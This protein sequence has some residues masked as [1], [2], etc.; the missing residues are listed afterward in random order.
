MIA[1]STDKFPPGACIVVFCLRGVMVYTAV[2]GIQFSP[3]WVDGSRSSAGHCCIGPWAT[4]SD[5]RFRIAASEGCRG[6]SS[7]ASTCPR[8]RTSV[9]I[10]VSFCRDYIATCTGVSRFAPLH[11][12][13]TPLRGRSRC[14]AVFPGVSVLSKPTP[15]LS[16]CLKLKCR[17]TS[18]AGDTGSSPVSRSMFSI[19]CF[20]W[21]SAPRALVK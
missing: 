1:L 21:H 10:Q 3:L 12:N 8:R 15:A 18:Q 19:T 4:W 7:D 5:V 17:V 11:S 14:T 20:R 2:V 6:G 9:G 16:K 13:C